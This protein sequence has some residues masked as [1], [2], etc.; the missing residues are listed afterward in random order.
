MVNA[1]VSA[2]QHTPEA[3]NSIGVGFVFDVFA[4]RKFDR[5]M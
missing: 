2:F 4:D 5:F 3:F 1:I